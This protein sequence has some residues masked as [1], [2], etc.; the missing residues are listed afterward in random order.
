MTPNKCELFKQSVKFVGKQVTGKGYTMD[1]ADLVL[2]MALNEKTQTTVGEVRQ[3]LGFD[4]YYRLFIASFS[5]FAHHQAVATLLGP[6][7]KVHMDQNNV[8]R[9]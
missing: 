8:L 4:S 1:P 2:V 6:W 3:M 9:L 5:Y 7:L